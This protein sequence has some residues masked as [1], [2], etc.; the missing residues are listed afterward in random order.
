M[1]DKPKLERIE[2][3]KDFRDD[4][5]GYFPV[6]SILSDGKNFFI[7]ISES[8]IPFFTQEV[9]D[10]MAFILTDGIYRV[11]PDLRRQ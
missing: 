4:V 7:N 8:L 9:I 3:G 10:K 6:L 5:P 2:Y 1:K 11:R